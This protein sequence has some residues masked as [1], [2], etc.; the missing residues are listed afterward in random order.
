[1]P[2][3][4][5]L[6]VV[7]EFGEFVNQGK[8]AYKAGRFLDAIQAWRKAQAADAS[9]RGELDGYLDKAIQKQ[10]AM[11]LANAARFESLGEAQKAAAQY[12]L[13]LQLEPRDDTLKAEVSEKLAAFTDQTHA[14]SAALLASVLAGFLL[15]VGIG[16]ALARSIPAAPRADSPGVGAG[17]R[18]G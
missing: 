9:R 4:K 18:I 12:Q 13:V 2:L 17:M 5:D 1:M 11:H 15:L 6:F 3:D 7:K 10:A 16:V 14:M 8:V